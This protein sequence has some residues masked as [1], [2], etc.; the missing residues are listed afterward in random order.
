MRTGTARSSPRPAAPTWNLI[1]VCTIRPPASD[2]P[3]QARRLYLINHTRVIVDVDY[4]P[5]PLL[6]GVNPLTVRPLDLSRSL[7]RTV[8]PVHLEYLRNMGVRATLTT[9]LLRDGQLWGLIA[10]HHNAP[11]PV[12]EEVREL[13]DWLGQDLATQIALAEEISARRHGEQ[14]QQCRNRIITA[15]R[16]GKRL[17]DLLAGPE[18][19]DVLGTVGAEGVALINGDQVITGGRTPDPPQILAI[20]T[21]VAA[22]HPEAQT[23]LFATD[24]LSAHLSGAAELAAT[25]AGVAVFPVDSAQTIRLIWFRGEQLREVAW[26][27][28]PDKPMDLGPD[29]RLSPRRSFAAWSQIVR[30][31]SRRWHLADL[32]SV[33]KLGALI[34][35]EWRRVAEEALRAKDALLNDAL[36]SLTAHLA[37]LDGDGVITLVNAAWRRFAE[38]NGGGL[39]CLPGAN[40]LQVCRQVLSGQDGVEA[41][42]ALHGIQ[43]VLDRVQSAF[44]LVYP[45]DSSTQARWFE[46]R[47]LPLHGPD[48]GLV[49]AHEDITARKLAA[50]ALRASE[51]RL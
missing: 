2:I 26:G 20:A 45:C 51:E 15:L 12:S 41:A 40:Y 24:R 38:Q 22:L 28:N 18:L 47:V 48:P 17:A 14:L 42:A 9:S 29:G 5:S 32:D 1:S 21:G 39:D 30:L 13:A 11:L 50:E 31:R 27:G 35:I 44:T 4:A 33:R 43:Q 49:V 34:D 36:D 16:R 23:D 37:V 6:P 19:T 3:A 25:A 10:C 46:M 7:L 8:S